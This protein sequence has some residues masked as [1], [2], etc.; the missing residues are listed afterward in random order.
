MADHFA[1]S[2]AKAVD[3]EMKCAS[4][5]IYHSRLVAK[6]QRRLVRVLVNLDKS[7]YEKKMPGPR[8]SRPSLNDHIHGTRHNIVHEGGRLRCIDC[9]ATVGKHS[10]NITNWLK[11]ACDVLL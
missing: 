9:C 7:K 5:V 8:Q 11:S 6:V 10:P 1:G 2:V 4:G 3:L